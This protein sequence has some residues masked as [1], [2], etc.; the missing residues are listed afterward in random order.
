[1]AQHPIKRLF[2]PGPLTTSRTVK[3]AMLVDVGS[4]DDDFIAMVRDIRNRL[5]QLG[6]VSQAQGYEAILVQGSGTFGVEAVLSCAIPPTGKL[7]ILINGAYGDRMLAIAGR[8]GLTTDVLRWPENEFTDPA[9]VQ[10]RLA[11]DPAIT[12]VAVVHCE[13]TTGLVNPVQKLGEVVR[14][15]KRSYIV[16]AM[17]S[18]GAIPLSLASAHIDFLVSSANKCIEG[19]PGFSFVLARQQ[20]LE[21]CRGNARTLSL[22]LF[23]QWRGL[24]ANGQFRF[25][26]PTH[27]L[28]AFNQ[29]LREL[30]A[31][32]GV[33][34]RAKRYQANH[35]A[36]VQGMI[37]LG[38][39]LYLSPE[40]QSWIISAFHYPAD[41][42]FQFE[43]FYQR[44][45]Q[46]GMVIYP[47]KLG[48]VACFRIGNIGRLTAQDI[49]D[50]LEA[51]AAVLRSM[52]LPV[53]LLP[54]AARI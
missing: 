7:L 48:N 54:I 50:L 25:T 46:R 12:H 2:T 16:D 8:H 19:V 14:A 4:R 30:E 47:G 24:E 15:A 33:A 11:Q 41:P 36:L 51:V 29:A 31:E 39:Q 49:Q 20:A 35:A 22:D 40:L 34:G 52:N 6:E 17:S 10:R 23:E 1:M 27:A 45:A 13:T 44:L 53:P 37:A 26:P 42:A 21:S 38:F 32:G 43:T 9:A 5:L 28:L 18:F 3:E